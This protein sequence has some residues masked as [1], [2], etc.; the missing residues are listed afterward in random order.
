MRSPCYLCACVSVN[1]PSLINFSMRKLIFKKAGMYIKTPDP[2]LSA[3]LHK[4]SI[5]VCMCISRIVA[6]Q[7]LCK[8]FPSFRC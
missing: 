1:T 3:V 2:H 6:R 5:S 8:V 4:S 7:M